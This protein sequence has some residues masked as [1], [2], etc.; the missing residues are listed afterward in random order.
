[1][2][3]LVASI[4]FVLIWSTGFI[5]ARAVVPHGAPELILAVRLTLVAMLLGIACSH[6]LALVTSRFTANAE[7]AQIT[8]LPVLMLL[9]LTG[10]TLS[11]QGRD[12]P[13]CLSLHDRGSGGRSAGRSRSVAGRR[14]RCRAN[15]FSAMT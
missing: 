8:S 1:M 2:F 9:A 10:G 15:G 13:R 12:R 7:N 11:V 6:G 3:G 14:R 5:V 4:L